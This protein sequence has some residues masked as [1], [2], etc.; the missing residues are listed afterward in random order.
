MTTRLLCGSGIFTPAI[1]V[2]LMVWQGSLA[3]DLNGPC[4]IDS[5]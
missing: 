2:M 1:L 3:T 4:Y 5:E